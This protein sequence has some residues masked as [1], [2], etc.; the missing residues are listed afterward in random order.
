MAGTGVLPLLISDARNLRILARLFVCRRLKRVFCFVL[1]VSQFVKKQKPCL[2]KKIDFALYT[3]LF[4]RSVAVKTYFQSI[5]TVEQ[6]TL[7][8]YDL[9]FVHIIYINRRKFTCYILSLHSCPLLPNFFAI[10]YS[11]ALFLLNKCSSV[12]SEKNYYISVQKYVYSTSFI[13]RTRCGSSAAGLGGYGGVSLAIS[14]GHR[15]SLPLWEGAG[16]SE[17]QL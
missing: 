10:I 13:C 5:R 4:S 15:Q 2:R 9:K 7:F 17:W 11:N 16:V 3:Y 8:T 1:L 6:F 14:S 12:P